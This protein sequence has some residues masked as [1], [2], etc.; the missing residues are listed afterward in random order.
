MSTPQ[1]L[2]DKALE[3]YYTDLFQMYG[4]PGWK[5]L[6]EDYGRMAETHV[7]LHGIDTQEQL[8]FRKGQLDVIALIVNHQPMA[9]Y[10]YST[11]QEQDGMDA[12][13]PTGGKATVVDGDGD[14][15]V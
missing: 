14:Q 1:G 4:T 6:M 2:K 10:V 11:L 15:S 12:T 8:W 9:E 3:E 7:S 5:R 13:A